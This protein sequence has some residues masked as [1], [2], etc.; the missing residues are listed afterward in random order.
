MS[1]LYQCVYIEY[2]FHRLPDMLDSCVMW[3]ERQRNSRQREKTVAVDVFVEK[4]ISL[5]FWF[6]GTILSANQTLIRKMLCSYDID[7]EI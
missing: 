2:F 6:P 4:Y 5:G 1:T 3:Q 7:E